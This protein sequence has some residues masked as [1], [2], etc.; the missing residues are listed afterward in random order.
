[1]Y[2][3]HIEVYKKSSRMRYSQER[4]VEVARNLGRELTAKLEGT[5]GDRE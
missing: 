1:M 2:N 5:S 3:M 4:R